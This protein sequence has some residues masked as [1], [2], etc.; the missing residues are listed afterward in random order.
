VAQGVAIP[1]P[2]GPSAPSSPTTSARSSRA[3]G[4]NSNV[5]NAETENAARRSADN[6]RTDDS[7]KGL[8]H[9]PLAGC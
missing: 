2:R 4:A 9:N 6:I 7:S 5:R 3:I 8:G 1:S